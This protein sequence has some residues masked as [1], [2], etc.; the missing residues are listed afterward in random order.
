VSPYLDFCLSLLFRKKKKKRVH[1]VII[2]IQPLAT[3]ATMT[4]QSAPQ[5]SLIPQ[6]LIV[7]ETWLGRRNKDCWSRFLMKNVIWNAFMEWVSQIDTCFGLQGYLPRLRI[8]LQ[9]LKGVMK[10]VSWIVILYIFSSWTFFLVI[11]FAF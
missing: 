6:V 9:T 8:S 3:L 4:A 1:T 10:I 5:S 2:L 7:V 11:C